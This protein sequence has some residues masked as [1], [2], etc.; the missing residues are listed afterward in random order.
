MILQVQPIP[1]IQPTS[2]QTGDKEFRRKILFRKALRHPRRHLPMRSG[3]MPKILPASGCSSDMI[4]RKILRLHRYAPHRHHRK[5]FHIR[6][7]QFLLFFIVKFRLFRIRC[8]TEISR[9]STQNQIGKPWIDAFRTN[10]PLPVF[11]QC[12]WFIDSRLVIKSQ[13]VLHL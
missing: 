1:K 12:R 13:K 4:T 5:I 10:T 3:N 11:P 7:L 2:D 6:K 8:S 9:R